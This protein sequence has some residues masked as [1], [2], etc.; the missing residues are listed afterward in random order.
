MVK[1]YFLKE[2]KLN[3]NVIPK[4]VKTSNGKKIE[5]SRCASCGVNSLGLF[6]NDYIEI[7]F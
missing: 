3:E 5:E 2:I 4:I 7:S 6:S 1:S